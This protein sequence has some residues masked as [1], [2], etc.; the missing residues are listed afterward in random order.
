M[1]KILIT[2][3]SSDFGF[4]TSKYLAEKGNHICAT[5]RNLEGKNGDSANEL[6]TCASENG[7]Y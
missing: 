1:K 4:D 2:G 5:M 6:R 3:T 7:H